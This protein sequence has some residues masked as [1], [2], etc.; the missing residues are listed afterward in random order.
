MTHEPNQQQQELIESLDGIHLVDAG[1][2]TGKTFTVSQRYSHILEERDVTPDD[3]LLITFTRSAAEEMKERIVNTADYDRAALRDAPIQTFHSLCKEIVEEYGLETPQHLGIDDTISPSVSI[4]EGTV[5]EGRHFERFYDTFKEKHPE[6][7][8]FYP[9]IWDEM[10]LLDLIRSL[11]AKGVFPTDDGWYR[12]G[13][14]YIDGDREAF[15]DLFEEGNASDG[16]SQSDLRSTL[17][18]LKTKTFPD[19]APDITDIRGP[20]GTKQIDREW[21]EKAFD[22]DR[23]RLKAFIHDLYHE[24]IAYALR[25]NYLNFPFI[26][27]FAFVLLV[28][29]D[30]LR[31]QLGFE[32][33]M[34]DEFQDTSEIQFKLALLFANTDN[35]CMVGDW[36]QSIFSFQYASVENIQS[37]G[38]RL[39]R[40]TAELNKDETRIA[41]DLGDVTR[42]DLTT[43][44]RSTQEILDTTEEALTVPATRDEGVDPDGVSDD[45]SPLEATQPGM[46]SV[47]AHTA[48]DERELVLDRIQLLVD[49]PGY[50][51]PDGDGGERRLDYG[52]VAVFSRD[53]QFGLDLQERA[54]EYNIPVAFEGGLELFSTRPA[55]LL[56]AW[57]RVLH[58]R[59]SEKG[60]AVILEQAGYTLDEA[61]D[62]LSERDYPEEM[63]EFRNHLDTKE[64]IGAVAASVFDRYGISSPVSDKVVAEI[65]STFENSYMNLGEIIRFIEDN[66]EHGVTYDVDTSTEEDMVTVQTIHSAKGLE[67]PA[68]ILANVN[69]RQFPSTGGSSDAI[70]YQ[71]PIGLFARKTY[72]EQD[73]PHVYDD[74]QSLFMTKCLT[75]SYDEERRLFYVALT[76]AENHL[77]LTAEED[78]E[79]KFFNHIPID[80]E[81]LEPDPQPA[82]HEPAEDNELE[83]DPIRSRTPLVLPVSSLLDTEETEG[84]RGKAFGKKV[85]EFAERYANGE[86]VEPENE[87]ERN[88]K[89]FIDSLDGELLTE[90]PGLLPLDSDRRQIALR[91]TIDLIEVADDSVK[92]IDYKTDVEDKDDYRLQISAY[93]HLCERIFSDRA[94][95]SH[96]FFTETG[97]LK[98]VDPASESHLVQELESSRT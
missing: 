72:Q 86:D 69:Q 21:A 60:W 55:L 91:G 75:S 41:Y 95:N 63:L 18:G 79:S 97:T 38:K 7:A 28:E 25:R 73:L 49:N 47:A 12:E 33:V 27:M 64:D 42:I 45:I 26:Q 74:W 46:T 87:D 43:N 32:Y 54:E 37:F 9:V 13:A 94:V 90:K 98:S 52:D 65:Q 44:Y 23:S 8:E 93:H 40:Y 77:M 51:V 62:I 66:I 30:D 29:H 67:Y 34:V 82:D 31:K 1:A 2:G 6:H 4:V 61:D 76:R 71:E 48:E 20:R 78:N 56:L 16:N 89:E 14:Q 84:G 85:H 19:K 50:T 92:V 22:A 3:I 59:H 11:A 53:R 81:P 10:Q 36:K 17:N 39:Q 70:D 35:L 15:L 83:L 68:V 88:V 96:I 57:L 5:L 24:Y 58:Y 80:P